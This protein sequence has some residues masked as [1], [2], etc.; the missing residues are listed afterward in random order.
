MLGDGLLLWAAVCA[1]AGCGRLGYDLSPIDAATRS[2]ESPNT[3]DPPLTRNE[4]PSF[5]QTG[6]A[7]DA[8]TLDAGA[9]D[10]AAPARSDA[11]TAPHADAGAPR[12]ANG[13]ACNHDGACESGACVSGMCCESRCDAPSAC[14]SGAGATCS[15][16]RCVYAETAPDGTSCDDGN[17]CTMNDRCYRGFCLGAPRSC[18]DG[19]DCT[20][21]FC[22][23]GSCT[24]ASS[25]NPSDGEC[26]YGLFGDHG[27]WLCPAAVSFEQARQECD[28]IGA[29]LV[30]INS[31]EEQS[32]LW[33]RGMRDTWIGYRGVPASAGSGFEWLAG[34]SQF[35]DW[36]S[37]EPD[38]GAD[39]CAYLSASHGGAW[40]SHACDDAFGGFACELDQYA[41][42]DANCK[43]LRGYEQGYYLCKGP[44]TW[45]EARAHCELVHGSLAEIAGELEQG[46]VAT[47]LEIGTRYAIGLND[48]TPN[49]EF[50][51][52]SGAPLSWSAWDDMQPA[53]RKGGTRYVVMD[54]NTGK[55]S[56]VGSSEPTGFVCE[57]KR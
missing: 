25:C 12:L 14:H 2:A 22:T 28:R 21:D 54:G 18:D 41:P 36:A 47:F 6:R 27:Y 20:S 9:S 49:Q 57:Q 45:W 46:Y 43:Y 44:R 11:G 51:W 48:R 19:Q 17:V 35:A 10:A 55:W 52:V 16:G 4:P 38:A 30:T 42:P 33:Q 13:E 32:Y 37:G 8:G 7:R 24:H 34:D 1:L 56:T 15:Q 50:T 39:S 40:E 31:K 3:A 5:V 23:A 26:S 29:H 53:E